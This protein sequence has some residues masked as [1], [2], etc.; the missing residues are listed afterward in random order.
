M[1]SPHLFLG[2]AQ[3]RAQLYHPIE[4]TGKVVVVSVFL[5]EIDEAIKIL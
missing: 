3:K 5:F 1:D 2:V 4:L